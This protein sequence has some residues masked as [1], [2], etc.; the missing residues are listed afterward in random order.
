[1][2]RYVCKTENEINYVFQNIEPFKTDVNTNRHRLMLTNINR[3]G[4]VQ[5]LCRVDL[6]DYIEDHLSS[7][8]DIEKLLW[9]YCLVDCETGT[10]IE[11]CKTYNE[12]NVN[13]LMRENKLNRITNENTL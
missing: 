10:R 8:L 3:N 1:M 11:T 4:C 9:S 13:H 2:N 7:T 12:I 5:F 6:F